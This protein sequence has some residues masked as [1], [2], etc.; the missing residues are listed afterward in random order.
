MMI[1]LVLLT[2]FLFLLLIV[3]K[4]YRTLRFWRRQNVDTFSA[5][6]MNIA[7]KKKHMGLVVSD[8]YHTMYKKSKP[9]MVAPSILLTT[10]MLQD[11]NAIRDV[12]I[13]NFENFSDRGGF[14]NHQDPL[15]YTV[16]AM[17]YELWKP[18]RQKFTPTFTPAKLKMMFPILMEVGEQFVKVIAN[19]LD[20]DINDLN[21]DDLCSRFT[22]DVIGNIAFG[23]ECN[24]LANPLTEFR[25]YGEKATDFNMHPIFH[26][27]GGKYPKLSKLLNF[28]TFNKDVT[29]FFTRIV[30]QTIEHREA[31]NIRR[32]DFMD[33][34]IELK[35]TEDSSDGLSL[36]LEMIVAQVFSFFV[37]GFGTSSA[38]LS[39]A[40]YELARNQAIQQK[41]RRDVEE[42][43]AKNS[44]N[45]ITYDNLQDMV[46][47][48]QT[49]RETLRKYPVI[50][51]IRRMCRRQCTLRDSAGKVICEIPKD[52][53]I[54]ISVYGIHHNPDYYPQPELFRPERFDDA[55]ISKRPAVAYLPFGVGPRACMGIRFAKMQV[56]FCL[57]LLLTHYRFL[58]SESTPKE[59]TFDP[60]NP[61]FLTVQGGINLRFE[62]L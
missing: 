32:N 15:T 47:L 22:T 2:L 35:K 52:T 6:S 50:P 9:L 55:E 44:A 12:L 51:N 31:N 10:V 36:T 62:K 19:Q 20:T 7:T 26:I 40:L 53:F 21:I 60:G 34:L 13:T 23:I 46:Y 29:E 1:T 33:I 27:I 11:L 39:F 61:V 43:L 18:T 37:A 24:S 49:I 56:A 30:Q 45:E 42:V 28:K 38:T 5:I 8:L 58:L 25:L 3:G 16:V 17:T 54:A 48:Q 57:A 41:V 14:V 4:Y 59:L